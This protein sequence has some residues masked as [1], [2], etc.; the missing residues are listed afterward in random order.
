PARARPAA[1]PPGSGAGAQGAGAPGRVA[2]REATGETRSGLT[3][4]LLPAKPLVARLISSIDRHRRAD[5]LE[6]V[7]HRGKE[8][9]RGRPVDDAV[10][11]PD[12]DIH[13]LANG[14]RVIVGH[15]KPLA[16]RL[17]R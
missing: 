6:P 10:I 16:Y 4:S 15:D 11:E 1:Q 14:D 2:E 5:G 7:A 8:A 3:V 9:R 17:R 13:H 12:H